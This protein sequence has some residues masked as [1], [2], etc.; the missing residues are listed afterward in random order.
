MF[1]DIVGEYNLK[2]VYGFK[3]KVE[4]EVCIVLLGKIGSGKSLIGNIILNGNFF[5]LRVL[6]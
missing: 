2:G 6:C 1:V 5:F 3:N 4:D